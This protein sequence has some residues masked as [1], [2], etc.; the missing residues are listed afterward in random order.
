M[1]RLYLFISILIAGLS[2]G[3]IKDY[4]F[5]DPSISPIRFGDAPSTKSFHIYSHGKPGALY[6]DSQW[7][8][9]EEIAALFKDK[10]QDTSELYIYG[11]NFAQGKAGAQ[12]VATL[13]KLLSVKVSASA[14]ITGEDGDWKMETGSNE[15]VLIP[16][17]FKGNLQLDKVHYLNPM[18][19]SKYDNSTITEE[20]IYLSTPSVSTITVKM[21]YGSG[22][23][24][25]RVGVTNLTTS[26]EA[27]ITDGNITL[28]NANPVRIR[29]LKTDNAI[30]P[31]GQTP[32]TIPYVKAGTIINGTGE[33]LIF[34]STESFYVNYRARS[35]SQAG[36][37]M[38]KGNAALGKEF[39]W[40]GTP[41]QFQTTVPE[42][43]T[44]LSVMAT[45]DNTT[46]FISN[47]D[48][49]VSFYNGAAPASPLTGPS[50]SRILNKGQSFI[51]YAPVKTGSRTKQ[52]DGWL[53]AK[54]LADKNISVV[55]GGI[56][57]Q[58]GAGDN[59]DIGIDQLVPKTQLG[60]EHVVMQGNGDIAELVVVVA[61][62]DNTQVFVNG[63]STAFATLATAGNWTVIPASSFVNNNMFV[64][65]TQ[66][67]YIFQKIFGGTATNTNNL[68]FI[69]P[70]DCF[71]QK[72]VDLIPDPRKIGGTE[73]AGTK[74]VILAAAGAAN[75]PQV[76]QSGIP[77]PTPA[78]VT[79]QGLSNWVTYRYDLGT[80]NGNIKITSAGAI[81][82]ELFGADGAAGFGG[83]YSGFGKSPVATIT[84]N[85]SYG[86]PCVKTSTLTTQSG[87]GY[88]Y[89]WYRNN[90]AI[91]GATGN[92]Y[93]FTA[94]N[95]A[96]PASYYVIATVPGGCTIRSN[97]VISQVCPCPKPGATGTPVV[98][99][100]GISS[101][102]QRNTANWPKDVPN[103]FIALE[104]ENKGFVITRMA[105]PETAIANPVE[106]MLV[107]DTTDD[108]LKL[109][110]GT[111]WKC[112][113]Q[114][115]ND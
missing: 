39:R 44:M 103:G 1:K 52:D 72:T 85:N 49:G 43:G 30:L 100:F 42:I 115:C 46:V 2:F 5:V 101:R 8:N 57:Q 88:T 102:T 60:L 48:P 6:I 105:E 81:Q 21:A 23:G 91:P 27:I 84:I 14:N 87:T 7:R 106:G 26:T 55:V 63:G 50:I 86:Y 18:T 73:Y 13:E 35:T 65:T 54:V 95:D 53:G 29:F 80:N 110:N 34:T 16:V 78:Q 89:Q 109:Y 83:Y 79:V 24:F 113:K 40:G 90:V 51:L 104:A 28:S 62:Y 77:L 31:P 107:Y 94:A 76:L 82:A 22:V 61:A 75:T 41:I 15:H 33:G 4:I 97:E 112:I 45:E 93:T 96:N 99:D 67:A 68:M 58:G 11:C 59:R 111:S 108:C 12:A 66:P 56:M 98:T 74:L 32:T 71:G 92:T 64:R 3:S 10:L 114:T 70:I 19:V 38:T 25:P 36:S 17:A 47:M 9:A 69:P 37:V 20:F